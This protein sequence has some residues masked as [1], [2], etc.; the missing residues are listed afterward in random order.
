MHKK[1]V[2]EWNVDNMTL[3]TP[4][5][6]PWLFSHQNKVVKLHLNDG[7]KMKSKWFFKIHY[8]L[9]IFGLS[10]IISAELCSEREMKETVAINSRSVCF[11][12]FL[13]WVWNFRWNA[14]LGALKCVDA[15]KS[16]THFKQFVCASAHN[17]KKK[18]A[19]KEEHYVFSFKKKHQN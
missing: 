15:S 6:D 10:P 4:Q 7:H 12:L 11:F 18:Q 14:V 2:G 8:D 17:T 3:V 16:I 5:H 9:I 19:D 13:Q 1:K